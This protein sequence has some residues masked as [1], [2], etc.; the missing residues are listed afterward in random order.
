[1]YIEV[2]EVGGAVL[3]D[4]DNTRELKIVCGEGAVLDGLGRVDDD[5]VF[6]DPEML[7]AMAGDRGNDPDWTT[8]F[9]GMVAYARAKG[10]TDESGAVRAHVDVA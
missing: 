7:R 2:T 5:H 1:M 6:L 4:V 8:E 3:R 9:N 10:W